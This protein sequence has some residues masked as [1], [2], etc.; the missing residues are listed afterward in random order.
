MYPHRHFHRKKIGR[1]FPLAYGAT[2]QV[3]FAAP[4][5]DEKA[6]PSEK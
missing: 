4:R 1:N 2:K 5:Y 3:A 6:T